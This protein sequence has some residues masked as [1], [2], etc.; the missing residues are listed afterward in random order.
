MAIDIG[1][2]IGIE[3]ESEFRKQIKQV[4]AEIKTLGTEMQVTQAAFAGQ[5]KSEEALTATSKVLNEQITKQKEKIDLLS[6]GLKESAD[7]YGENDEKTLKWQQA[8]NQATTE[9]FKMEGQLED[10][11]KELNGEADSADKAGKETKE[12]GDD[13]E[14]SGAGWKALGDTVAAVGAAMAAAA[15]A[16]AAAIAEAG[17]AL[18]SF[19]VDGAAYADDILTMSSVTGMS[20]E[21]LQELQYA[22]DLVDV[23]VDTITGSMKKNLSAMTKVQNG[24]EAMTEVYKKLGVE[25]LDA[26]GNLRDDE[27]VYWEL[28]NALG[29]VTDETERDVLAMQVLGKSASDLN[30]LIEAG[31]D[32]MMALSVQAHNAGAVLSEDTLDA[33]GEFDDQLVK[34]DAG[35]QAAKNAL[36]TILLPVLTELAGDGVNLLGEFSRGIL[37]ADG[38][39]SKMGDVISEVLPKVLDIV[40]GYI[41]EILD[42]V[43]SILGAVGQSILDNLGLIIDSVVEVMKEVLAGI[44]AALPDIVDATVE[45]VVTMAGTIIDNLP[46]IIEAAIKVIV[47]ITE[48]LAEALP[49]LIPAMVDAVLLICDTVI[50]NLDLVIDAALKLIIALAGGLIDALPRLLEKAPEIVIKLVDAIIENAPKIVQAALELILK[51]A[52]GLGSFFYKVKEK[53]REIVDSIK[54]GFQEKV[55]AAKSWGKDL[56]Q[57]FVDGLL[58]KWEELKSGVR[59]VAQTV[60]DFLGF[61]EPEKGPLSDFHTYAP[62]MI[63]LFIRGLQQG[64]RRL[65]DQLGNTF[66][67]AALSASVGDVRAS[68]QGET[69]IGIRDMVR[70]FSE[71]LSSADRDATVNLYLDGDLIASNTIKRINRAA[72]SGGRLGLV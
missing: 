42:L 27:T 56:I 36:G 63:D 20:T 12:A 23:S 13:A 41:P 60:K 37:D 47:A 30:P 51:L 44:L 49:E 29:Q 32:T 26:N 14:K 33:F 11:T 59:G 7:K 31:A 10:T 70:A 71:A 19:S 50:N 54:E 66:S 53:G 64:Q 21:K 55:E 38:D 48:G 45:L 2:K 43:M 15:A 16:A 58:A 6:K 65:Q 9:L 34:L 39:I 4:N 68:T 52:E 1:P 5:E 61:S 28:I 3:G 35:A 40:M 24:N 72:R 22:A 18:V 67:T 57:N 62:D 8:V 17:K 46:T 69:G 25:V